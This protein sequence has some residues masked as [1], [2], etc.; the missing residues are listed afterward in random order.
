MKC[1]RCKKEIQ[2]VNI[3]SF[4]ECWQKAEVDKKRKS[5]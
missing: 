1:P 4:N 2:A 3:I 5:Y